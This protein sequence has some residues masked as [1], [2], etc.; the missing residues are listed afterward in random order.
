MGSCGWPSRELQGWGW[1]STRA[2][3]PAINVQSKHE[4]IPPPSTLTLLSISRYGV[5]PNESALRVLTPLTAII[6][7]KQRDKGS[8]GGKTNPREAFVA[9]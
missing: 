5:Q 1:D 8:L 3:P 9:R 7:G 6:P 4:C 2:A